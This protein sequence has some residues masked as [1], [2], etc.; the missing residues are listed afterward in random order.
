VVSRRWRQSFAEGL[1]L[2]TLGCLGRS[3]CYEWVRDVSLDVTAHESH[4]RGEPLVLSPG[5]ALIA[6]GLPVVVDGAVVGGIGVDGAMT[7]AEDR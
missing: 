1:N 3:P 2:R 7:G 4:D 6:S 5:L